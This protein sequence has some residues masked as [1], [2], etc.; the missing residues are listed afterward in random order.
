MDSFTRGLLITAVGI[1]LPSKCGN[2]TS[3]RRSQEPVL[4]SKGGEVMIVHGRVCKIADKEK[5]FLKIFATPLPIVVRDNGG[6]IN[7]ISVVEMMI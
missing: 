7:E 5:N 3:P 2:P 1:W 6:S 4:L